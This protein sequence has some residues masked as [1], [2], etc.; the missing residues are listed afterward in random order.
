MRIA[1]FC[2]I[3]HRL[4]VIPLRRFGTNSRPH[5]QG[6]FLENGRLS[7]NVGKKLPLLA[8]Y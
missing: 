8:A 6:F 3:T 7:R 5:I 1:L 2:V 4:V